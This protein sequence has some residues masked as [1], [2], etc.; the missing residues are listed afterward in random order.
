MD[1]SSA[2]DNSV[3]RTAIRIWMSQRQVILKI[4]T[5]RLSLLFFLE[6]F[7]LHF[8]FTAYF[9]T[10]WV[11]ND[12]QSLIVAE[13]T[14][15]IFLLGFLVTLISPL[16]QAEVTSVV[17]G[18]ITSGASHGASDVGVIKIPWWKYSL[19]SILYTLSFIIILIIVF[20][21]LYF[22]STLPYLNMAASLETD[23]DLFKWKIIACVIYLPSIL[24]PLGVIVIRLLFVIPAMTAEGIGILG[25]FARSWNISNGR[26]FKISQLW[27]TSNLKLGI[28]LTGV[29][30]LD[31]FAIIRPSMDHGI[32]A[33][34][35]AD[36]VSTVILTSAIVLLDTYRLTFASVL[37]FAFR[38]HAPGEQNKPNST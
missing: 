25:A 17:Y 8:L 38:K 15:L 2:S 11:I 26:F 22:V 33:M 32:I 13:I 3:F 14:Y 21:L 30:L 36:T 4:V 16:A 37:Y 9:G 24:V 23:S 29:A 34:Y 27:G 19:A 31:Y 7:L 1:A 5:L 35:F 20:Q 18:E 12:S 10:H 6:I 28:I